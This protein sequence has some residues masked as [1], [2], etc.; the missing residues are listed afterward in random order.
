MPIDPPGVCL[1]ALV[2]L[3]STDKSNPWSYDNEH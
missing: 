2:E 3:I 1:S